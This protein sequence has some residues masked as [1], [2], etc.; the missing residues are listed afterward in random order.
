MQ[1]QEIISVYCLCRQL[2]SRWILKCSVCGEQYLV[3]V[4]PEKGS[5]NLF[6][7]NIARR[8]NSVPAFGC[9]STI[10]RLISSFVFTSSANLII[11]MQFLC[12]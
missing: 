9:R 4:P 10:S 12:S 8:K 1:E 7:V 3:N 6:T 5:L 11:I 2:K